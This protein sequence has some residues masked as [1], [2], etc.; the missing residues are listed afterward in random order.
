M[1]RTNKQGEKGQATV[2]FAIVLPLVLLLIAGVIE[3]G[4]AFNY[5]LT[6]N[7]LANE[8]ARWAAVNKIPPSNAAPD[9]CAIRTYLLTQVAGQ[10]L[11]DQLGENGRITLTRGPDC[12]HRRPGEGAD[13]DALLVPDR[14]R[15]GE[16]RRRA[17]RRFEH[18]SA[19][20]PSQAHRLSGSSSLRPG[21]RVR[22]RLRVPHEATRRRAARQRDRLRRRRHAGDAADDGFRHRGRELVRPPAPDPEPRRQ[23]SLRRRAR[24]RL[25]LPRLHGRPTER[26]SPTRSSTTAEAV[27]RRRQRPE[28]REH[29]RQ[30]PGQRQRGRELQE[31]H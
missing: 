8:G 6:L 31:P 11:H 25:P 18:A 4:K 9:N 7:H 3:F 27:R 14:L 30:R 20:S 17:V 29:R 1:R 12:R 5:W 16:P 23:R 15:H 2:E 21:R 22:S 26:R 10:E 13:P 24:V 28:R 19:T